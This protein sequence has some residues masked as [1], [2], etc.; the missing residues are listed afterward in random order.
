MNPYSAIP[1]VSFLVGSAMWFY[2][3][4][5]RRRDA[6]SLW[7]LAFSGVGNAWAFLEYVSWSPIPKTW[8]T[9]VMTFEP[10]TW[11]TTGIL[12]LRFTYSFLGRKRDHVFNGFFAAYFASLV[13]QTTTDLIVGEHVTHHWGVNNRPGL[14]FGPVVFGV[15]AA[16][17]LYGLVAFTLRYR[18]TKDERERPSLRLLIAG[19]SLSL[20]IGIGSDVISQTVLG[21]TDFVELAASGTVV[22][23]LFAGITVGTYGFMALG[24]QDIAHALFAEI[25]DGVFLAT[26]EGRIQVLNAAA[27]DLLKV[28]GALCCGSSVAALLPGYRDGEGAYEIRLPR[29][30]AGAVVSVTQSAV[31][32]GDRVIAKLIILRDITA[33]RRALDALQASEAR[34]REIAELLPE[35]VFE[36]DTKG[37]FQ[38]LNRVGYEITGRTAEDVARGLNVTD[39]V[40]PEHRERLKANIARRL[41]GE[42]GE[43]TEFLLVAAD[44]SL[45]P[46]MVTS[47][48]IVREDAVVGLRGV[49]VN[50]SQ[51]KQW[52]DQ[53][54]RT[55]NDLAAANEQLEASRERLAREIAE[56]N[57]FMRIV[58]HDLGAPLRNI[59]GMVDSI[60]RRHAEG[61]SE[62]VV[63]RLA[64]IHRNAENELGLIGELLE[65]SRIRTRRDSAEDVD[66]GAVVARVGEVLSADIELKGIELVVAP[67]LPTLYCEKSRVAQVFQN[68]LDNAIK[69]MPASAN[70]RVEIGWREE[71]ERYVFWVKDNGRGIAP[72]DVGGLFRVFHRAAGTSDNV[73]GKGVGLAGVRA[74]A[75]T[76]DGDAWVESSPGEG[77]TFYFSMDKRRVRRQGTCS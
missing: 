51:R 40:A 38:F 67:D 28:K 71:G 5:L 16:P 30:E 8:L 57:D 47:T 58:S 60:T 24:P 7:F 70:A 69:Y 22:S 77:S 39:V 62:E 75:Q 63:D 33:E 74:I 55:A 21:L 59:M 52:E 2:V 72:G 64:R 14:L 46:A 34:F 41:Q 19:V 15:V 23:A 20:F 18:K 12:F 49:A 66:V 76:Y 32:Q 13:I 54:E 37:R 4:A 73:A 44:G 35:S 11:L 29:E 3:F 17:M 48:P 43:T 45:V 50:I 53:L 36:V 6:T 27:E 1:F 65:L 9:V 25:S 61:L 68:Y 31:L 26:P 42:Q 10:Y 56:K